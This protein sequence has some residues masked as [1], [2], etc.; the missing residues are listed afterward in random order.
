M[1]EDVEKKRVYNYD[2]ESNGEVER[3]RGN[4]KNSL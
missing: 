4:K 2:T 1:K 3:Q